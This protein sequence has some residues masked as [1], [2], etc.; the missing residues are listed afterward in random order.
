MIALYSVPGE[1]WIFLILKIA[2]SPL[3]LMVQSGRSR[4]VASKI[5]VPLKDLIYFE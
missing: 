2:Y 1:L 4:K 5:C 3:D